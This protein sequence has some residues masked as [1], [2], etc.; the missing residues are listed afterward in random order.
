MVKI[1]AVLSLL[2]VASAFL[3]PAPKMAARGR[4]MK[5]SFGYDEVGNR[6]VGGVQFFPWDTESLFWVSS[7]RHG[8]MLTEEARATSSAHLAPE[9]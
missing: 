8:R 6:P 9:I 7:S 5:M 2:P 3:A 1:A 4:S